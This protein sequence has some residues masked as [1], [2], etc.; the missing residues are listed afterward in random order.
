MQT[1]NFLVDGV[2]TPLEATAVGAA[3]TWAKDNLGDTHIVP[4]DFFE[5]KVG[6]H[7][8]ARG[9][10][11]DQYGRTAP[12]H[13][14]LINRIE[15]AIHSRYDADNWQLLQEAAAALKGQA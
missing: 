15:Y 13:E 8:T 3:W 7:F 5:G 6:C 12:P 2:V 10:R 1:K 9:K 11:Y 14:D 4:R